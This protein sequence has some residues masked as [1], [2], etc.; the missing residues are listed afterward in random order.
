MK[1]SK[2]FKKL[3]KNFLVNVKFILGK[4][5]GNIGVILYYRYYENYEK[6]SKM[7]LWNFSEI[8]MKF[9]ET[10]RILCTNFL[11]FWWKFY[12]IFLSI[13]RKTYEKLLEKYE[14]YFVA[15]VSF[16]Y[17]VITLCIMTVLNI[18]SLQISLCFSSY[19]DTKLQK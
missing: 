9:E 7:F 3:L 14:K 12:D 13:F 19:R 15:S 6:I 5:W 18:F 10:W 17:A 16:K 11:I 2:N 4:L 1:S 8:V